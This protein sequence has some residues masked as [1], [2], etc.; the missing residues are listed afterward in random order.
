MSFPAEAPR[1]R[2]R[3]YFEVDDFT[4]PPW[5]IAPLSDARVLNET[6]SL[7]EP[8]VRDTE[9]HFK[10]C[11]TLVDF[12]GPGDVDRPANWSQ[13]KRWT[14]VA[15]T[16]L[17][18]LIVSFSSSVWSSTVPQTSAEFHVSQD[19]SLLGVS[20]FVLG[21]GFGPQIFG[22]ASEIYGRTRPLWLGMISFCV[23]QVPLA[24]VNSITG[25]LIFRF[26]A[27]VCGS[28]PFSIITGLYVD[29]LDPVEMGFSMAIYIAAVYCGPACGPIVGSYLTQSDLGWRSTVWITFVA[30]VITT[31]MAMYATPET[32]QPVILRRR[33]K[34]LRLATRNFAL[35]ALSEEQPI[36]L[37][38]FVRKYLTKPLSLFMQEP[39]L[40]IFTI[41]MSLAYGIL[42][43][44]FVMYPVAFITL[45]S[46]PRTTGSLPFLGLLLGIFIACIVIALH[47]HYYIRGK[48][49][50]RTLRP[51]DRLPPMIAGSFLLTGGLFWFGWTSDHHS[52]WLLQ[53]AAGV[54][55]GC[56]IIL[57]FMCA[58]GY[59]VDVYLADANSALAINTL[60][61]SSVAAAFPIV[62]QRMFRDLGLRWGVSLLGFISLALLPFPIVVMIFGEKIRGWSKYAA[63]P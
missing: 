48:M 34:R 27:G 8:R 43:L 59:L 16:S 49:V 20:L 22:P 41:Y 3:I 39:I 37:Q 36:D 45:R 62:G 40:V 47:S 30:G 28:A 23:L 54:P 53:T 18:T 4:F 7:K 17:M 12:D 14:I 51:E 56:G 57:V 31:A 33:A 15:S 1:E 24:F 35:H 32:F 42:Y 58:I 19:V 61:R 63:T 29:M 6:R 55:L 25:A 21:F 2:P 50:A 46:W 5:I 44:T 38:V 13:S 9:R 60:I 10:S 52:S 26:L 11:R